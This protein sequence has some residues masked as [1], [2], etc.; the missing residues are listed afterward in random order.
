MLL[1]LEGMRTVSSSLELKLLMFC[2]QEM[3]QLHH[4]DRR[5]VFPP[6]PPLFLN[7]EKRG[8]SKFRSQIRPTFV[9]APA[10]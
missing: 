9:D 5:R 7:T 3:S 2:I 8:R 10:E 4:L 1:V 6:F